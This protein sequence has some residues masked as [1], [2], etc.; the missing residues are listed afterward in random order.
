MAPDPRSQTP[1]LAVNP[2][3][4]ATACPGG[5][6]RPGPSAQSR[7]KKPQSVCSPQE[8]SPGSTAGYRV[9]K[10]SKYGIMR[11]IEKRPPKKQIG[12]CRIKTLYVPLSCSHLGFHSFN[13]IG[14]EFTSGWNAIGN[15][16]P[17]WRDR[18]AQAFVVR[19][20]LGDRPLE[21]VPLEMVG[22][23][24]EREAQAAE[25]QPRHLKTLLRPSRSR[26]VR[27]VQ[28]CGRSARPEKNPR[29]GGPRL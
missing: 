3:N 16:R 28:A 29:P 27:C 20:C 7:V 12:S 19:V 8:I 17:R 15:P 9:S 24:A 25:E 14:H 13:P 18:L 10:T 5:A 4:E 2:V 11:G 1:D 26:G 23:E 6:S 21:G 22:G